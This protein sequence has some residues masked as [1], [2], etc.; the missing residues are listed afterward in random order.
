MKECPFC[1]EM[2][3]YLDEGDIEYTEIDIGLNSNKV[4]FR[5]IV[6]IS[7]ADSVPIIIVDKKILMPDRSFK[8]IKEGFEITK[9]LL[10]G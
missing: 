10:G 1:D 7:K 2:K 5:K 8:T 4:E 6:E 9:K 3:G